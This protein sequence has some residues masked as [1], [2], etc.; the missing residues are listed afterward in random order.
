[1]YDTSQVRARRVDRRYSARQMLRLSVEVR[2]QHRSVGCFQT[3]DMD[4]EGAFIESVGSNLKINDIIEL[5]FLNAAGEATRDRML[6]GV[7]RLA[8]DGVGV[9][10]FDYEHKALTVMRDATLLGTA[11]R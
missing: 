2:K 3:R 11:A 10:L 9:V 7:V 4:V 1:M 8:A 5:L 6:A